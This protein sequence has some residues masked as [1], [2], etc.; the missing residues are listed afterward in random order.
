MYPLI[1]VLIVEHQK[2]VEH[3]MQDGVSHSIRFGSAQPN[4]QHHHSTYGISI[5]E[6]IRTQMQQGHDQESQL[7]VRESEI[8]IQGNEQNE[9]GVT[10][11][12]G[13]EKIWAQ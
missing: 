5:I 7:H 4:T 10:S 1:I 11:G 9:S 13:K 2:S 3:S 6:T 12:M 8:V